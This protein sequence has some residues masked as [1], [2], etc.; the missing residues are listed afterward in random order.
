M[1]SPAGGPPSRR[2]SSSSW[3]TA[4]EPLPDVY[5][6]SET[7]SLSRAGRLSWIGDEV[8][9]GLSNFLT[10]SRVADHTYQAAHDPIYSA[11]EDAK[12]GGSARYGPPKR[13]SLPAAFPPQTWVGPT[14]EFVALVCANCWI[15]QVSLAPSYFPVQTPPCAGHPSGNLRHH[16]WLLRL[17]ERQSSAPPPRRRLRWLASPR[18][19][20]RR[21]FCVT[22]FQATLDGEW[23]KRT[24]HQAKEP[25]TPRWVP[26]ACLRREPTFRYRQRND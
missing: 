18:Y 21:R 10:E 14:G 26:R 7:E 25:R 22:F 3:R 15:S 16:Q 11:V 19:R 8:D 20:P 6:E 23:K 24:R 9:V 12:G 4:E 13:H 5:D 17:D 2:E 1:S